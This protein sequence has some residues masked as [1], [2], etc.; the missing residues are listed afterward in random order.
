MRGKRHAPGQQSSSHTQYARHISDSGIGEYSSSRWPD[1]AMDY[2]PGVIYKGN[3]IGHK[4]DEIE[5]QGYD[6]CY[7]M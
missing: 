3:L 5:N 4:F 6:Y 7:G 1:K 2:I